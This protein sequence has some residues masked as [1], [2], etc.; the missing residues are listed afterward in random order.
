M[1]SREKQERWE[2]ALAADRAHMCLQ[3]AERERLNLEKQERWEAA[4][5]AE[6]ARVI[7]LEQD[8]AVAAEEARVIKLEQ[9]AEGPAAPK[10]CCRR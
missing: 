5:A 10:R 4:L 9:V 1:S 6:E 3:R 2:A 8:A 7:K